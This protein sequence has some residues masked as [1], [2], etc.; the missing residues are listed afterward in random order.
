MAM[1]TPYFYNFV[2]ILIVKIVDMKEIHQLLPAIKKYWAI[3]DYN[4]IEG[5]ILKRKC[6]SNDLK[7]P[8]YTHSVYQNCF[9][10]SVMKAAVF[11][12]ESIKLWICSERVSTGLVARLM[13]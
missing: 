11:T 5:N 10:K 8:M 13:L 3:W 1:L 4:V 12:L 9:E 7:R 6:E 2:M